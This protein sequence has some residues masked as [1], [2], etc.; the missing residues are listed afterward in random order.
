MS[1]TSDQYPRIGGRDGRDGERDAVERDRPFTAQSGASSSGTLTR[2]LVVPSDGA[3][4]STSPTPS[5]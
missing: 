1:P 4:A 2:S 5:T 3:T